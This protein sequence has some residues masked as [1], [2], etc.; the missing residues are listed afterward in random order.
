MTFPERKGILRPNSIKG[1]HEMKWLDRLLQLLVGGIVF[2][3]LLFVWLH[4]WGNNLLLET[5]RKSI[6]R[7][8]DARMLYGP[9]TINWFSLSA[10]IQDILFYRRENKAVLKKFKIRFGLPNF[11]KLE[12]PIREMYLEEGDLLL[13]KKDGKVEWFP[14]F[15]SRKKFKDETEWQVTVD[16]I[17]FSSCRLIFT[18]LDM[19]KPF[20]AVFRC[21]RNLVAIDHL[22]EWGL[23]PN[24]ARWRRW[25]KMAI[26]MRRR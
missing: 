21:T 19:E 22:N 20:T 13:N 6:E 11:T 23:K 17:V 18:D 15:I 12:M 3:F 26:H 24:T 1:F 7:R 25:V 16:R 10:E 5:V 8:V 9:V 4:F 14:D 2:F